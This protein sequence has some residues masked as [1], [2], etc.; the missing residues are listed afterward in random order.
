MLVHKRKFLNLNQLKIF[1]FNEINFIFVEKF[2][3]L[4]VLFCLART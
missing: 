1:N 4:D 2:F 3:I